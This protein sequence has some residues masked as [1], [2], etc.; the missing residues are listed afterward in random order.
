MLVAEEDIRSVAQ[1]TPRLWVAAFVR[2]K[3]SSEPLAV[4]LFNRARLEHE[5]AVFFGDDACYGEPFSLSLAEM[6]A[7]LHVFC[8]NVGGYLAVL[9]FHLKGVGAGVCLFERALSAEASAFKSD[10]LSFSCEKGEG[11]G[12]KR[13]ERK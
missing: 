13:S 8:K 3:T 7:V 12:E 4:F 5:L 9:A 10:L 2:R 6:G 11:E 1:K